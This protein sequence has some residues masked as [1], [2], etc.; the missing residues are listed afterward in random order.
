M[1]RERIE[2]DIKY[3]GYLKRQEDDIRRFEKH[4]SISIPTDFDFS[5]VTALSR[6]GREKLE[7]VRPRS[8]GQASRISGVTP[9]DISV[10]MINLHKNDSRG[11]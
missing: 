11:T 7:R 1:E 6:E 3:E 10:V 9:A 2:I 4:E 5:H 8:V